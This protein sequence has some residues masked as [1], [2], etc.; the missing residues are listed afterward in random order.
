MGA[1]ASLAVLR[2]EAVAEADALRSTVQA[3]QARAAAEAAAR[4]TLEDELASLRARLGAS[5]AAG[6]AG[7]GSGG[8]SQQQ[9]PVAAANAPSSGQRPTPPPLTA[10]ETCRDN[11]DP[12][13]C[14][15]YAVS[16]PNPCTACPAGTTTHNKVGATSIEWCT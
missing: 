12:Y 9:A 13:F 10:P 16:A 6:D 11:P 2:D 1:D 7:S 8:A 4:R 15:L 5:G 3:L 14:C